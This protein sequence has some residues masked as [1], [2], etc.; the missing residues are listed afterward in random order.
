MPELN[1]ALVV[2]SL[3]QFLHY[4]KQNLGVASLMAAAL[5]APKLSR[6]ERRA[7]MVSGLAGLSALVS[8]P[9]LLEIWV[10]VSNPWGFRVA[11]IVFFVSALAGVVM[12][13]SRPVAHR[14]S[15]L[16]C[17]VTTS[18]FF[19]LPVF[20]FSSPYA[21]VSGM[22]LAHGLQYL[23]LMGWMAANSFGSSSSI[24]A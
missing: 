18:S 21:A 12:I 4:Q 15:G 24:S 13:M 6:W 10:G 20:V 16:V 23:V 2:F 14:P 1:W 5:G 11:T 7:I 19:F 8:R 3:W 17:G 9:T 22:V